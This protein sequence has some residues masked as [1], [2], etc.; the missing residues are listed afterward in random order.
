MYP[1]H[2]LQDIRQSTAEQLRAAP[3]LPGSDELAQLL[4]DA[5]SPAMNYGIMTSPELAEVAM[6]V[7]QPALEEAHRRGQQEGATAHDEA[8]REGRRFGFSAALD[9]LTESDVALEAALATQYPDDQRISRSSMERALRAASAAVQR[10]AG[11]G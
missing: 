11:H 6:A 4:I 5:L 3:R 10:G 9:V 8:C 2:R 7:M 1:R